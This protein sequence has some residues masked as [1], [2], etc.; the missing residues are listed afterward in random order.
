MMC[1]TY[2]VDVSSTSNVPIMDALV[3]WQTLEYLEPNLNYNIHVEIEYHGISFP[4]K[5][6]KVSPGTPRTWE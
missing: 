1:I 2:Y 4:D 6:R 5:T 3:F